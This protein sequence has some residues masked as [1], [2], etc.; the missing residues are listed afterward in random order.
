MKFLG[1]FE[2]GRDEAKRER[3]VECLN[4]ISNYDLAS[5]TAQSNGFSLSHL[6]VVND[7]SAFLSLSFLS[8][9][10]SEGESIE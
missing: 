5:A 3:M 8:S 2:L 1:G 4:G 6:L 9:F 7:F 10:K